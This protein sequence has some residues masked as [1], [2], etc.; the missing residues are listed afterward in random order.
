MV[1]TVR[2][3]RTV[4]GCH[5]EAPIEPA[6][7]ELI[8]ELRLGK[9]ESPQQLKLDFGGGPEVTDGLQQA[10]DENQ[11]DDTVEDVVTVPAHDQR[12][13]TKDQRPKTKDQ[14]PKVTVHGSFKR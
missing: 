9:H 8:G 4:G 6:A 5:S 1:A 2:R 10:V 11:S 13:K 7:V 14:R 3:W 12:P